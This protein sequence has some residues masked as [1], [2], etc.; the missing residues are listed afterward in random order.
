MSDKKLMLSFP[1]CPYGCVDGKLFNTGLRILEDCPY[2]KEKREQLVMS[3]ET[4]ESNETDID[5][6]TELNIPEYFRGIGYSEES[7]MPNLSNMDKE[8]VDS[9]I[10]FLT[11]IYNRLNIKQVLSY[12][13][14][15][16]MGAKGNVFSFVYPYMLRAYKNGMTVTPFISNF[17]IADGVNKLESGVD[18]KYLDWLNSDI[19]IVVVQSGITQGGVALVRGYMQER[20]KRGKSTII[21]TNAVVSKYIYNT[22]CIGK[23][24]ATC[25]YLAKYISVSYYSDY[26]NS[27]DN[28]EDNGDVTNNGKSVITMEELMKQNI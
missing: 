23:E 7:L 19:S 1:D 15:V 3:A 16:N 22:L 8:S 11:E 13:V 26:S 2:C 10:D 14:L 20:A 6:Y 24:D 28:T 5:L 18:N 9:V 4:N 27:D 25:L 21:F 17:D 12:S